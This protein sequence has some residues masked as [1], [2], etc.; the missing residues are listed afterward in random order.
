MAKKA[1]KMSDRLLLNAEPFGFG[2]T[3]AI[4]ECFPYLRPLFSTIG[5]AGRGH[6][7]D[8]QR[9]LPYSR[10]HDLDVEAA[11]EV[12]AGYDIF[13]TALDFAMAEQAL[14]HGL[15]TIIYDPLTWYWQEIHP[16]VKRC[17]LYISQDFLGVRERLAGDADR[18]G[19]VAVVPPLV[20]PLQAPLSEPD[21]GERSL[22]LLNLGGLSNPHWSREQMLDYARLMIGA[23]HESGIADGAELIVA[24]NG[25]IARAFPDY[26]AGPQ[27]K[28][29]IQD[30]MRRSKLA[31]MTPGLGNIYDAAR[32]HLPTIWLPPANDSQGQQLALLTA[33]GYSDGDLDW[34]HVLPDVRIDYRDDQV[35][36]LQQIADCAARI[37]SEEA[38]RAALA[39]AMRRQGE[40]LTG[41]TGSVSA[42]LIELFGCNGAEQTAAHIQA[43]VLRHCLQAEVP[44]DKDIQVQSVAAGSSQPAVA[45]S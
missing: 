5:F 45:G 43:T 6:T 41:G 3:A 33:G 26:G 9:P 44:Y 32:F 16:V 42:R 8:L 4:A 1:M 19:A 11:N 13:V 15:V 39:Q 21:A 20:P 10:V 23:V 37:C 36:V 18:F 17:H 28:A 14:A 38:L 29:G 22:V 31:L 2:P 25:D 7:L 27:T 35:L 34:S 30:L 12:F 24:G 40:A